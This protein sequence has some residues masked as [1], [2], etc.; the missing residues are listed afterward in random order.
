[1]TDHERQRLIMTMTT[2]D[3]EPQAKTTMMIT[4]V[5]EFKYDEGVN[6]TL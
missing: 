3:D 5:D 2:I 4:N 1:M 6:P